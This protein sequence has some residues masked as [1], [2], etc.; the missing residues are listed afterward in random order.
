MKEWVQVNY[1]HHELWNK[2]EL[3]AQKYNQLSRKTIP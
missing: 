3:E 1:N 2:F